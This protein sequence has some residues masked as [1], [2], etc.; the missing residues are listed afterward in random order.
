MNGRCSPLKVKKH[1]KRR[2]PFNG[3]YGVTCDKAELFIITGARTYNPAKKICFHTLNYIAFR[4]YGL[5]SANIQSNIV[6]INFPF[7]P[8]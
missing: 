5:I 8:E 1:L 7:I 6:F 4:P 3:L 2:L